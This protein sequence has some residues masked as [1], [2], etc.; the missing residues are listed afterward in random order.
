MTDSIP[1]LMVIEAPHQARLAANL[2]A[3]A[4]LLGLDDLVT[5]VVR[6]DVSERRL[7]KFLA[8]ADS[9]ATVERRGATP[10]VSVLLP[11]VREGVLWC[12]PGAVIRRDSQEQMRHLRGVYLPGLGDSV[13]L[14]GD[15]R[16]LIQCSA[17]IAA[18]A[19]TDP[20]IRSSIAQALEYL[21]EAPHILE[22]YCIG[23][24]NSDEGWVGARF[25]HLREC[26]L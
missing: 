3:S 25:D 24:S 17:L 16:A 1:Y 12:S 6:D 10:L 22:P 13:L 20:G 18:R 23:T 2:I 21:G 4:Q 19:S 11:Y 8:V 15:H 7:A 26:A 9:A 14:A 5:V